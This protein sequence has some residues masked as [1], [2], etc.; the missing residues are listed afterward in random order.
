[1]LGLGRTAKGVAR[2]AVAEVVGVANYE[3]CGSVRSF[4][5]A[6]ILQAMASNL[7]MA[8]KYPFVVKHNYC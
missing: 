5:M 6:S 8:S 7:L 3:Y 1:M 2:S 4:V